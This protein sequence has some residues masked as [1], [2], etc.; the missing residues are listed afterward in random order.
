M[1]KL[2]FFLLIMLVACSPVKE[3]IFVANEASGSIS[4]I[5]AGLLEEIGR[6]SLTAKHEGARVE[7]APHNVQVVGDK[8]LVTA[9][10][11][12]KESESGEHGDHEMAAVDM[13]IPIGIIAVAA[14]GEEETEHE[15]HPDQLVIIDAKS[16]KIAKR[17]DLDIGAHLA[18]VVSDGAYAYVTA[19]N[20]ELL[21]KVNLATGNYF[22][23][24]LPKGSMPHGIRLTADN[25]TAII[26]GM[27]GYLL[28][29]N[30]ETKNITT[31]KLPGKGV[32]AGVAG[33]YAMASVFDTRQLALY[34][35]K[36]QE[37]SF[38]DLTN[39]KGP[40]QMYPT[41]DNNY[42]Y[43]ADQ[44]VYFDQPPGRN[45]YKIDLAEKKVVA[46]IDTGDAP[47]GVVVSPDGRVWVTNLNGNTVSVIQNDSKIKEIEVGAS[48]N[49]ISYWNKS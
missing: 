31:I 21:Y 3:K 32:Q 42:V 27:T 45:T 9:N 44:G 7:Y 15:D 24:I 10:I 49:G 38:V 33:D 4:V 43:I 2:I 30:L 26:A 23:V 17:I 35:M 11:A 18:H 13:E 47:H 6:I 12:H 16:H 39:A 37:L 40:I 41:P 8:V 22:P 46:V 28:L 29:V 48:P 34:D 36:T 20:N 5:D 19:T 14:H 1:K 25:K